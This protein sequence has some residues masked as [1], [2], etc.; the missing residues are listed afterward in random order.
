MLKVQEWHQQ[1]RLLQQPQQPPL[2]TPL[3]PPPQ[4][5]PPPQ[6]P[7]VTLKELWEE[8]LQLQRQRELE[9]LRQQGSPT[10]PQRT[11]HRRTMR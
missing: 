9:R 4:T 6:A 3:D 8:R 5:Q 1:R 10:G 2:A 7:T 11:R